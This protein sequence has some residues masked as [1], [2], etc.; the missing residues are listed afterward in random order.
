MFKILPAT[1]EDASAIARLVNSSYRG[2]S[3][4]Q[5]WTTEADLLNGTRTDA[6]AI[7]TLLQA[8]DTTILKYV[9]ASEIKGCVEL[10]TVDGGLYLGM[11][12]VRPDLQAR[13]I[14]KILL[15]ASEE[16]ARMKGCRK[17]TMTV[18]TARPE[19]IAWYVRHGYIDTGERKPFAFSDPRFG[20]PKQ[21]LEFAVL[22]KVMM[23]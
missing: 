6:D 20:Q 5:G 23:P 9:E 22:E 2:E 10:K 17:I 21:A 1:I 8:A 16:H 13:G 19:L 4:K 18:I 7:S 15:G 14:G 3:S 11:L 12:T